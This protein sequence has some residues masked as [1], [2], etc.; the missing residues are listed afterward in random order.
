MKRLTLAC[1]VMLWILSAFALRAGPI[2]AEA[3]AVV[4]G[5]TIDVG[6]D[7]YRLVGFDTPEIKTPRRKVSADE[8]ALATIAKARLTE[9]QRIGVLDL[10]E[11]RCSCRASTIGTKKC[12]QGRKCGVLT[13]DGK[14]I[15]ATLIAEALAVP[16]WCRKTS[17]PSMP[18]WPRTIESQFPPRRPE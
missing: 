10:T 13:L 5:D 14:N 18:D 1:A 17:C 12:N 15:G 4:D 2:S 7:R 9:L 3:V 16:Y 11:V 6:A 8:R